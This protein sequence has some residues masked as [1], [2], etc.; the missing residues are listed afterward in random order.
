MLGILPLLIMKRFYLIKGDST[1]PKSITLL[2]QSFVFEIHNK[3]SLELLPSDH[4][5]NR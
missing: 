3:L 5:N 2:N 4:L 1:I